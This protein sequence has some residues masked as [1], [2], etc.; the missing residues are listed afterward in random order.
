M[1]FGNEYSLNAQSDLQLGTSE[2]SWV[3]SNAE[4]MKHGIDNRIEDF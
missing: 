3:A 4:E 1:L 2:E